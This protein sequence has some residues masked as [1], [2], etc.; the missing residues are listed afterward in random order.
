MWISSLSSSSSITCSSSFKSTLYSYRLIFPLFESAYDA[1]YFWWLP[2]YDVKSKWYFGMTPPPLDGDCWS[3]F[4]RAA[5]CNIS[6]LSLPLMTSSLLFN[7]FQYYHYYI[8]SNLLVMPKE[9]LRSKNV[10][11]MSDDLHMICHFYYIS[12]SGWP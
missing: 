9:I 10:C 1:Y 7:L 3:W 11:R 2:G 5:Y 4:E 6:E 12:A 8:P